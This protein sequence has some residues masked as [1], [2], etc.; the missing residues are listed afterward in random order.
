MPDCEH[1]F[2]PAPFELCVKLKLNDPELDKQDTSIPV[3]M[4]AKCWL[5]RAKWDYEIKSQQ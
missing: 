4:C 5:L 3:E 1:D 2:I